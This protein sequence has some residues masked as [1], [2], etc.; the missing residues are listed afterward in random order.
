MKET[1]REIKQS[2][3]LYM[4][5]VTAQSLRDKGLDYHL[6]WGASLGHLREMARD[7]EPSHELAMALWQENVRECKILAT[8]LMPHGEM[9]FDE[10]WQWV[11]ETKTQEIAELATMH[12][13]QYLP[14]AKT[15]ALR[16]IETDGEIQQ[17]QENEDGE[18]AQLSGYCLLTRLLMKG[19]TLNEEERQRVLS[20]AEATLQGNDGIGLKRHA[21]K[22][23]DKLTN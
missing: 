23:I 9:T 20:R 10:A 14:F 2:F 21:A 22:A 5:G 16:L 8:L 3:R 17:E 11:G 13:Y 6:N 19:E 1:L 4:N 18:M 12:L 7:Y 15:L